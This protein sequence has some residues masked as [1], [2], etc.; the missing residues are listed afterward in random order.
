MDIAAIQQSLDAAKLKGTCP[1]A[2]VFINPGNPTGTCLSESDI[3][4]LIMFC[5]RNRLVLL[6][7]EVYM[8]NIYQPDTK[9]FI[10]ARRVLN[11]PATPRL[12]LIHI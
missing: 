5:H 11:S 12:S 1:R 8:E 7:D 6:A 9:P 10:S 4:D 2:L 3:R